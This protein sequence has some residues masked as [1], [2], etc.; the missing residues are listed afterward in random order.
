MSDFNI[1]QNNLNTNTNINSNPTSSSSNT[2]IYLIL[3][4]LILI[5][6]VI[7]YNYLIIYIH[8]SSINE[9]FITT[10][11]PNIPIHSNISIHSNT[12]IQ[13]PNNQNNSHC[14]SPIPKPLLKPALK[15][16]TGQVTVQVTG[17][18][19]GQVTEPVKKQVQFKDNKKTF[20]KSVHPEKGKVKLIIIHMNGCHHCRD[21]MEI[22]LTNNK[23]KFEH[24]IDIFEE[25]ESIQI[26]DFK[27]GRDKEAEPYR[28][29]PVILIV[30]E[31]KSME[32][33]GPRDVQS[34]SKAIIDAKNNLIS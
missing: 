8:T 32:Y 17:Q 23:T 19:T 9:S 11:Y 28:F 33:N 2:I 3:A 30:T 1:S 4:L 24:I 18:V 5:I 20:D 34:I 15:P 7:F 22:K 29:L 25:D 31:N 16:A 27:A 12:P 21:L 10:T 14:S 26:M 13:Q 6:V